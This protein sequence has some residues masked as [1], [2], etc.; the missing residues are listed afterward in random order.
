MMTRSGAA[1]RCGSTDMGCKGANNRRRTDRST[2]PTD[3][4]IATGRSIR[5][6]PGERGKRRGRSHSGRHGNK[7]RRPVN[8]HVVGHNKAPGEV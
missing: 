5:G 7:T 1:A 4:K 8:G 3:G 2:G 6:G